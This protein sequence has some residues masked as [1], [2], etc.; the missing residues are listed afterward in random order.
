MGGSFSMLNLFTSTNSNSSLRGNLLGDRKQV[1]NPFYAQLLCGLYQKVLSGLTQSET[2]PALAS[3]T[4][5]SA[6]RC[7]LSPPLCVSGN[8]SMRLVVLGIEES[9]SIVLGIMNVVDSPPKS[10]LLTCCIGSHDARDAPSLDG[11][12]KSNCK[13]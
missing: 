5:R 1:G 2:M 12:W 3:R 6:L 9:Y 7:C 4:P 10:Y 11:K 13:T 8:S